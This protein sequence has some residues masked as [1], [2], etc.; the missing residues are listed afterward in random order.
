MTSGS[1]TCLDL[2][3]TNPP[4]NISHSGVYP[5]CLSEHELVYVIRKLN[6]KKIP[7]VI[8]RVRNYSR[9]NRE[10]FCNELKMVDWE[11]L[12][13][14]HDVDSYWQR[15]KDSFMSIKHCH[16]RLIDE[17]KRRIDQPWL[18]NEITFAIRGGNAQQE[19]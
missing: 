6:S 8:K 2:V 9:Y 17:K 15:F 3:A 7:P 18:T 14:P 16:V 12:S 4:Q 1:L 10:R 5:S 11:C 13:V 19:S